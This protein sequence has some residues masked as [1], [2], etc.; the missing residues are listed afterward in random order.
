MHLCN[1]PQDTSYENIVKDGS[2]TGLMHNGIVTPNIQEYL[3]LSKAL[4]KK[5]LY[6]TDNRVERTQI[7]D[8]SRPINTANF[9]F[10]YL[11]NF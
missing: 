4:E 7:R 8:L 2:V 9:L 5:V 3:S 11:F 1:N 6:W 10:I